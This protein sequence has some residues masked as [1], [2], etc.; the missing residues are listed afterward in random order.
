MLQFVKFSKT[1]MPASAV[2]SDKG[3]VSSIFPRLYAPVAAASPQLP[4]R[5]GYM[6]MT[7]VGPSMRADSHPEPYFPQPTFAVQGYGYPQPQF[8]YAFHPDPSYMAQ[9]SY[10]RYV[11]PWG[12]FPG[13][14]AVHCAPPEVNIVG[15]E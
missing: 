14:D 2:V 5:E 8:A 7:A 10:P 3:D 12:A 11:Y 13:V 9:Y 1:D 15:R 6:T 4:V